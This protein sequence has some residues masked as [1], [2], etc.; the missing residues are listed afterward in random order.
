VV[1]GQES[2]S[3]REVVAVITV[4]MGHGDKPATVELCSAY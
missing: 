1:E 2:S 4:G 3:E